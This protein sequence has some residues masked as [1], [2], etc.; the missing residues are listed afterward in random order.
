MQSLAVGVLAMKCN[1]SSTS[2]KVTTC[3][4]GNFIALQKISV[5]YTGSEK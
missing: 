3:T 2:N 5:G 4:C 1:N